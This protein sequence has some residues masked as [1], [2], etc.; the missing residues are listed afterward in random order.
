MGAAT[1][2]ILYDTTDDYSAG[3]AD[4]FEDTAQS[5]GVTITAKEG[6]Q[7]GATDFNSQL[8][9]IKQGDPQVIMVPCYYEDAAKIMTQARDMGITAMFLGSDGWDG[10]LGQL[11]ASKYDGREAGY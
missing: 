4:T 5:L 8:T 10:V 7:Q 1:A 6:Y 3:I 11:D 2:A 9:K